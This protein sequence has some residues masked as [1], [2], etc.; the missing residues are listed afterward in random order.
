MKFCQIPR[1][2]EP[3]DKRQ[4][5]RSD[6]KTAHSG[7]LS[8]SGIMKDNRRLFPSGVRALILMSASSVMIGRPSLAKDRCFGFLKDEP[9]QKMTCACLN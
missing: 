5:T 9:Q 3:Q 7:H 6:K 8:K 2:N 1:Y 4:R